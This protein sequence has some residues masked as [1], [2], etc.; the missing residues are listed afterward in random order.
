[1]GFMDLQ[2]KN[3]YH[4]FEDNIIEDFYIPV[5][6]NAKRYDRAVG[7]FSSTS[8]IEITKGLCE[9]VKNKGHVRLIVS[10][11]LSNEDIQAIT[12]GYENRIELIT[13]KFMNT[14]NNIELD[15]FPQKRLNLLSYLIS[16]DLL[17]IKVAFIENTSG[18]GIGI[19]HDKLGIIEDDEN[20]F[21]AFSGSMNETIHAFSYNYE[22]IDTFKSWN[23]DKE[24]VVSK[25]NSFENIWNNKAKNIV[26]IDFPKVAIE[27]LISFK[28]DDIDLDIDKQ[29]FFSDSKKEK[30]KV[31]G[32]IIPASLD[33][34][35]YQNEA[36]KKW[37][38]KHFRG[39]FNMAT[40]TG[41]TITGLAAASHLSDKRK[42][43]LAIIIVCPYKH[44][45]EQWVEDINLFNM[46]PIVGHS[47]S[48]QKKWK[49]RLEIEIESYKLKISDHFCFVTTNASF[50]TDTVQSLIKSLDGDYLL[51]VDEA[52]NF[53]AAHLQK[54]LPDNANYRLGLSATI[55][56]HN[57]ED[58]TQT[59]FD[60]FGPIC[61]EYTL[62]MAIKNNMLTRYFYHPILV[63]LNADEL[64]EY[65]ELTKKIGSSIIK[66]K[67]GKSILS[68]SA[69]MLLLK[70][71]KIVAGA[72]E[73]ISALETNIAPF[74]NDSHLLVYCG[75]TTISDTEYNEDIV[76]A[77]EKR[78][79]DVVVNLLGN[80]L[81]MKISKF[82]SEENSSERENIK[83]EFEKATP[84][85]ALVAIRCLDEGV[86]IPSIQ[87]AFILASSTNPKEY[88]QRRGRVLR[89]APGKKHADIY[90]FITLPVP[91]E[92]LDE[93]TEEEILS[94]K[95]L[96]LREIERMKDFASVAENSSVADILI[97][98]I[99]DAY[100]LNR[101]DVIL[102][103]F[104]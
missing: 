70:R 52:H 36:I 51:I 50:S 66:N 28:N 104:E 18:N 83:E 37:E 7:Y 48:K 26:T 71:A 10:P 41:K 34:R 35:P 73:K 85:Q 15:F 91:F 11:N 95:S 74:K 57:D 62:E 90:D 75:V 14:L 4:S 103:E 97:N 88:I 38:E 79:I 45:V 5:L 58:G 54:K 23:N 27:K 12:Y 81:G 31:I 98:D 40:G 17:E 1:M 32:P 47:E 92:E 20:N 80:T 65:R 61:I 86:N 22:S 99:Q 30:K 2:I 33:I 9:L 84:L 21:I 55:N 8:L 60:Y 77:D 42:N 76:D 53:G 13:N 49:E 6:S 89:K 64:L 46:N 68:E 3:E 59:L 87:K 63:F 44:L 43:K 56:R 93:F 29:E 69:K 39:I 25:I 101:E 94:Y 100:F 19:F 78:Q 102:N 67:F 72:K 82:T 24:R 96:P 16:H